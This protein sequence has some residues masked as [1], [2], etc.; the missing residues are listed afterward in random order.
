MGTL[1]I[2][3]F[4]TLERRC[5]HSHAGAWERGTVQDAIKRAMALKWFRRF[6]YIATK[7]GLAILQ[8]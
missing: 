3:S 4:Q 7:R 2:P 8:I 5:R 1:L 6:S